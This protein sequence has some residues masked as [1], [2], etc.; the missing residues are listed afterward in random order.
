MG[1][2]I[3]GLFGS[4]NKSPPAFAMRATSALQGV[5]IP[6]LL[7]GQQRLPCSLIWYG[8]FQ[9]QNAGSGGKGGAGNGSSKGQSGSYDYSASFIAAV[10]EG[11]IAFTQGYWLNGAVA[12][13][14]G[15]FGEM[16]GTYTQ[17]PWG[18]VESYAPA[19]ALGYRGI[20]YVG[21]QSYA[22]GSSPA[23]P[24]FPFEVISQ[25]NAYATPGQPDADPSV[26]FT[27]FLT[28]TYWG[29]GFPSGRIAPLSGYASSW[30]NY[31]LAAGLLVSPVLA[32][33]TAAASV[34]DDLLT[35][36]NSTACWQDGA[37]TVVPY[38]DNAVNAG[39]VSPITETHVIPAPTNP[40]SDGSG[41]CYITVGFVGSFVSDLGVTNSALAPFTAVSGPPAEGQYWM[42]SPGTYVFSYLD[43]GTT[44]EISYD[45]AATVSFIPPTQT[46]YDFTFDDMLDN[47]ATLGSGMSTATS[48][49]IV[50]R[51]PKDQVYN[52][53]K[54]EY[55]D[56]ANDYNPVEIEIKDEASIT[57]FGR[58]RPS[59]VKQMHCFCLGSAAQTSAAL[60]LARQAVMRQFQWTVGAHFMMILELMGVVTLTDP[61]Q[62]LAQQPARIIEIQ[63]N[64]DFTLTITAEEF[65]GNASAPLYGLQ[66]NG[67]W[68]SNYNE[69]PGDI[70]PPIIF[71]P[72][73]ELA[74]GLQIWGAVSGAV[75]ST[76]GGCQVWCS[77]DNITYAL[78]GT[79]QGGARMGVLRAA[80]APVAVNPIGPTIDTTHTLEIDLS[81]SGAS[82]GSGSLNDALALN[83]RCY[84]GGEILAFQ[85]ATLV[86][87][88]K[89]NLSYLVRGAYGT[90]SQIV[91]HP[92]G[93]P[94]ARLDEGIFELPYDVNKIG[95]TLYLKF[96]S[97]NPYG[98]GLQELSDVGAYTYQITG[99]ALSSPLPDVTNLS[100][101]YV[102]GFANL[103]WTE[104]S[105]FRQ[106]RYEIRLGSSWA[107]GLKLGTVAHPPFPTRGDGTFWIAAV[108]QPTAGL[109][110]YS[111]NPVSLAIAGNLLT[112]NILISVDE[113]ATGWTGTFGDDAVISGAVI[114]STPGDGTYTIPVGH[115]PSLNR[116]APCAITVSWAAEG[117]P[118]GSNVLADDD[119]LAVA[120]LLGS[121][122]TQYIDA[123]PQIQIG[124][125]TTGADIYSVPNLYAIPDIYA[126]VV[127]SAWQ[128]YAPGTY[129]GQAF[130]FQMVLQ[131]Q[132]PLAVCAVSAFSF[133]VNAPARQDHVNNY[134]LPSSGA[135]FLFT[136]DGSTTPASFSGGPNGADLPY[137]SVTI[138][139]QAAGDVL[140]LSGLTL[141]GVTIRITNGGSGVARTI[142]AD[143]EGF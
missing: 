143:F 62:G 127:W 19:Q 46:L 89:Y 76:W 106:L 97:F 100:T 93:T 103:T 112:S 47:Q 2:F 56:R 126:P 87:A 63:E 4:P 109:T 35:A 94:F 57:A 105:D 138:L 52:S 10:C 85:T 31:C 14:I 61:G 40:A 67:G 59:D 21:A 17:T 11:P 54:L 75:P 28:N 53:I 117:Y 30:S 64:A 80:L 50:H 113:Q 71:E 26:C 79:I 122:S 101:N 37:L 58:A 83:T 102:D 20:A 110:V 114:Q 68:T 91:N 81:E 111:E 99:S 119:I 82:L 136:P 131:T 60:M 7:G 24:N 140:V 135:A 25:S 45:Y 74:G 88:N 1:R 128:P 49:L 77:Y 41:F 78:V 39:T 137:V 115:I 95:S 129:N 16:N 8:D 36:T 13:M 92:T 118:T 33:Q 133:T 51:V 43:Q 108:A 9:W 84:V 121:A 55:L 12:S 27:Q 73:D 15:V 132:T 42:Q 86:A 18:Y 5:P 96:P 3:S 116:V 98:G 139:N 124:S 130:N 134:A 107:S 70:N 29:V 72:S 66:T 23:L 90:E 120:D 104:V 6:L 34:L 44:V 22:L 125:P 123:Y 48:P 32:S 69:A 142:N 141:A 65:L 38:G